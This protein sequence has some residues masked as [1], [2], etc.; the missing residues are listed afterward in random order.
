MDEAEQFKAQLDD[1]HTKMVCGSVQGFPHVGGSH[2]GGVYLTNAK[3]GRP[4]RD[5]LW[6]PPIGVFRMNEPVRCEEYRWSEDEQSFVF[7]GRVGKRV[8]R[9]GGKSLSGHH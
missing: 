9:S 3:L 7:T 2:D 6:R 5:V 8:F 4:T 1:L